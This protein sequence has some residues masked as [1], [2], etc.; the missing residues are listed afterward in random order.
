MCRGEGETSYCC[1]VIRKEGE[2]SGSHVE[3]PVSYQLGGWVNK[4]EEDFK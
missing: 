4:C 3:R 1:D 2:V